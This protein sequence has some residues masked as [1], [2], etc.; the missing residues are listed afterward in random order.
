LPNDLWHT[1]RRSEIYFLDIPFEERL[2]HLVEEYGALD[3]EKMIDAIIRIKER[4]GGLEAK[5]AI[6]FLEQD[7][8]IESFRILLKY[9]DKWYARGLHN[10]ENINSL[11]HLI[12]CESVSPENAK[13]LVQQPVYHEKT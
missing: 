2:K 4:L 1:I 3:K 7:N 6:E 10:R 9:Y 5:R 12:K 11:L 8:P 13:K